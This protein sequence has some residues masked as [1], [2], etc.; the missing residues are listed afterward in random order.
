MRTKQTW[1]FAIAAALAVAVAPSMAGA[2]GPD[3][4]KPNNGQDAKALSAQEQREVTRK[5]FTDFEARRK[6]AKKTGNMTSANGFL[7]QSATLSGK[8]RE[9]EVRVEQFIDGAILYSV[10]VEKKT[11]PVLLSSSRFRRVN[12]KKEVTD[13]TIYNDRVYRVIRASNTSRDWQAA[14][15]HDA[16]VVIQTKGGVSQA[17]SVRVKK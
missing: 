2:A 5:A 12:D 16:M 14:V 15:G 7:R 11:E 6:E 10:P 13:R 17:M 4:A 9:V 3:P 8:P 1:T